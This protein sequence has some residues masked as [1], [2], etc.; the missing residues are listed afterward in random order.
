ML[1]ERMERYRSTIE[2]VQHDS[3]QWAH[4]MKKRMEEHKV[5]TLMAPQNDKLHA[6][7]LGSSCGVC[8]FCSACRLNSIRVG[9]TMWMTWWAGGRQVVQGQAF[10]RNCDHPCV[11][12]LH[13]GSGQC[14]GLVAVTH[15]CMQH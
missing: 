14:T 1:A 12:M 9:D 6:A 7:F 10:T 13:V 11:V 5:K 2:D 15:A 4:D 3:P 8:N